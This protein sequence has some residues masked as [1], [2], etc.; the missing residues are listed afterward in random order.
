MCLR[1]GGA[2]DVIASFFFWCLVLRHVPAV[3]EKGERGR[4][5]CQDA[6][7]DD[8]GRNGGHREGGAV[9][10]GCCRT[11]ARSAEWPCPVQMSCSHYL[12]L[13]FFFFLLSSFFFLLSSFLRFISLFP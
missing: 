5:G 2:A 8:G 7:L 12:L 1:L 6:S 10:R 11:A 13:F 4:L 3:G 9:C